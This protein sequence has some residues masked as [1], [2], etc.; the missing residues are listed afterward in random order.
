M[1]GDEVVPSADASFWS[2]IESGVV[3]DVDDGRSADGADAAFLE[4]AEGAGDFVPR[5][6]DWRATVFRQIK[7][8]RGQQAFRDSLRERYGDQ[9]MISGCGLMDAVEA[10][11][12]KPYRGDGDNHPANGLLL[13]A[14]LHTQFDLDLIGIEPE[15]LIV[16]S[17][18]DAKTAGYG[19]EY[20]CHNTSGY[21]G[22]PGELWYV[23]VLP[24][25]VPDLARYHIAFTTPY[26]LIQTIKQDWLQFLKRGMSQ[27]GFGNDKDGL[28][29]FLKYGPDPHYWN[30]FVFKGYH[31]HTSAAISLAG[32]PDMKATLPHA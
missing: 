3:E 6:G 2:G 20:T 15:T 11:H 7:A 19:A 14:D 13:W 5:E 25:L 31:H 1:P 28:H 8:R 26:I 22:R 4:F 27:S 32:I 16:R 30:E 12:I 9:C 24:P 18:T 21:R 17:H 23:R 10:A 29:R